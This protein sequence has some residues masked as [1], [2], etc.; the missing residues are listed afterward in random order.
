[1]NTGH[2]RKSLV[3]TGDLNRPRSPEVR[4]PLVYFWYF[5]YTRKV[6]KTFL[7]QEDSR[8]CKPRIS[9]P[10]PQ[11]RTATI[12]NFLRKIRGSANLKTAHRSRSFAPQQLKPFIKED[13][14]FR[15]PRIS[16]QKQQIR[17]IQLNP[18][19]ASRLLP[20]ASRLGVPFQ[21]RLSAFCPEKPIKRHQTD[22]LMPFFMIRSK[23]L[24]P[25]AFG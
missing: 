12:K 4:K 10:Q 19:A 22:G 17:T 2:F 14:R 9:A 20:A 24:A 13:S 1:M 23:A 6:R 18:F 21:G 25:Q 11:L 3:S 15:K 16:A 8:F 7:S 5:S